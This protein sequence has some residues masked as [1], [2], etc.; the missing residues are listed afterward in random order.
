MLIASP[1]ASKMLGF[2]AHLLVRRARTLGI[3]L[4]DRPYGPQPQ[5]TAALRKRYHLPAKYLYD[6]ARS[7]VRER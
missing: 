3:P 1:E 5:Y 4:E 6:V 2:P 7:F